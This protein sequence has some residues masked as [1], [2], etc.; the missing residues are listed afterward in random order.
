MWSD[1]PMGGASE[2]RKARRIQWDAAATVRE[3]L[4]GREHGCQVLDLSNRGARLRVVADRQVPDIFVLVLSN[5]GTLSRACR[6]VWR[7]GSE[8]GVEFTA[9]PAGTAVADAHA[10]A[11]AEWTVARPTA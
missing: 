10:D 3:L 4:G 8:M 7:R 1:E 6:V 9:A 11:D 2:H 5:A